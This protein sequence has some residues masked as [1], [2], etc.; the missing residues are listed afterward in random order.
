MNDQYFAQSEGFDIAGHAL[1]ARGPTTDWQV[2]R[3]G[4]PQFAK[5][6][7]CFNALLFFGRKKLLAQLLQRSAVT[8]LGL[9]LAVL[10]QPL[11]PV[12][13]F[14]VELCHGVGGCLTILRA[15]RGV[16]GALVGVL[17]VECGGLGGGI[18]VFGGCGALGPACLG[19]F[20]VGLAQ[21]Q[22]ALFGC[23]LG[24]ARNL[25]AG[26]G[27][28]VEVG[29]AGEQGVVLG[30][31]K[32]LLSNPVAGLQR[33]AQCVRGPSG[34]GACAAGQGPRGSPRTARPVPMPARPAQLGSAGPPALP[35]AV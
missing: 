19:Q 30:A 8:L 34:P 17:C 27:V 23:E 11:L 32:K 25:Q 16:A 9:G 7:R 10:V 3:A 12:L 6:Q 26:Q 28:A 20:V 22:G 35:A 21:G 29:L 31:V 33:L 4:G 1:R 18:Q 24:V 13:L 14:P 2:S 5:G 15:A